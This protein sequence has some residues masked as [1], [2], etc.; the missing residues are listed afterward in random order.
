MAK[1]TLTSKSG[2]LGNLRSLIQ[3]EKVAFHMEGA[4]QPSVMT[5]EESC[6]SAVLRMVTHPADGAVY[7][8]AA[9]G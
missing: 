3:S 9:L 8:L 7:R 6:P 2:S 4:V 1:I 5:L